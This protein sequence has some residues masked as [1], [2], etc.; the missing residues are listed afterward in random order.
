[1]NINAKKAQD[2][3]SQELSVAKL[4]KYAQAVAKPTL[5]AL[6]TFCEQNEEFAQAVLQTDRT[7]AECAENAVKG[8]GG[9][10]SDIEVYRRA[11]RFYFKGADVHFN[12][13][14]DLGDGSDSEETAKPPVSLSLDS[15][16]DF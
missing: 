16:L 14:I 8:A 4:G 12:M 15:L 5:E 10:I 6:S 2:K 1:M 9:S 11:V 7:F 3:L 13:T